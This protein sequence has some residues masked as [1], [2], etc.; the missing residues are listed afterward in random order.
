MHCFFIF[1]FSE[2]ASIQTNSYHLHIFFIYFN[3]NYNNLLFFLGNYWNDD[4]DNRMAI[5]FLLESNE[6]T[7]IRKQQVHDF[8]LNEED[9]DSSDSSNGSN[10]SNSSDGIDG[11]D[12]S[13]AE[14]S[15]PSSIVEG[16]IIDSIN[17]VQ[18]KMENEAMQLDVEDVEEENTLPPKI[19]RLTILDPAN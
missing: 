1:F 7:Y 16:N 9:S 4:L 2:T 15:A 17:L 3:V 13:G 18:E 10:S 14:E 6:N 8:E 11:S 19:E 5:N 12:D